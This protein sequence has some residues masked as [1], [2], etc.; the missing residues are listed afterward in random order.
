M[1]TFS[2]SLL[3]IKLSAVAVIIRGEK[4][5]KSVPDKCQHILLHAT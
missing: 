4:T 5:V 3:I 2:R 1:K